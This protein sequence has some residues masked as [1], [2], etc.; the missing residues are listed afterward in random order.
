MNIIFCGGVDNKSVITGFTIGSDVMNC[1]GIECNNTS[2]IIENNIFKTKIGYGI[3]CG[4]NSLPL[5]SVC[6]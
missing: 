4:E 2:I 1:K 6:L 5:I 3:L